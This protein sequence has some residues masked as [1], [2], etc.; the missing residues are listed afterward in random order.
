MVGYDGSDFP[1]DK[2]KGA[3]VCIVGGHST[4][5]VDEWV[6]DCDYLVCV[7]D[8]YKRQGLKPHVYFGGNHIEGIPDHPVL[9]ACTNR[10]ELV[11]EWVPKIKSL[12]LYDRD[13]TIKPK[14]DPRDEWLNT[15]QHEINGSPLSGMIA[16][17]FFSLMPL[18]QLRVCGMDFYLDTYGDIVEY[19]WPHNVRHQST[20]ARNLWRQHMRLDYSPHLLGALNLGGE[21]KGHTFSDNPDYRWAAAWYDA[22]D[23][24]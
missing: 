11:E 7:N 18:D 1:Y 20:W 17:R 24:K 2:F 22:V 9:M 13:R 12:Y 3:K 16:L 23:Y 10:G 4:S 5:I 21:V 8:H 14:P 15:Y 6:S 19:E